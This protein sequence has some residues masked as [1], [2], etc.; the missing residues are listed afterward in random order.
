M[1]NNINQFVKC[2]RKGYM[3]LIEVLRVRSVYFHMS[4]IQ[5]NTRENRRVEK[6]VSRNV[7]YI[8]IN[9]YSQE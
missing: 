7:V 2:P 5:V 3:L 9:I 6:R 4:I 8:E 1:A